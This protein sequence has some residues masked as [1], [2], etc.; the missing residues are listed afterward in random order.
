MRLSAIDRKVLKILL[1][2]NGKARLHVDASER[3]NKILATKLGIPLAL[4]KRRRKLLEERFLELFYI[5]NLASLSYRRVDFLIATQAG[6]TI[7][8]ANKLMKIIEVVTVGR[9]IGEPTIDLR[10]ELIVKDN[11]QLFELLEQVKAIDGVRVA[12][13]SEIVQIVGNKGS[14]PSDIID[15]L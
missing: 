5:M 15:I 1:A 11:E 12:V 14:V 2:P 7:S 13:W 4:I 3:S 8:I 10:A 6:L 9:S